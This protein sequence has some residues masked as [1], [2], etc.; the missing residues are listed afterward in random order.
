M[1]SNTFPSKLNFFGV[2]SLI[3]M[4]SLFSSLAYGAATVSP[5][6]SIFIA[7]SSGN[8][9]TINITGATGGDDIVITPPA[10]W[11]GAGVTKSSGSANVGGGVGT[12]AITVTPTAN[13]DIT[14][15]YTAKA[16]TTVGLVGF[17][18]TEDATNLA[19]MDVDVVAD[20]SGILS[21]E[22]DTVVAAKTQTA[23]QTEQTI[24]MYYTAVGS[25]TGVLSGGSLVLDIPAAFAAPTATNLKITKGDGTAADI[26]TITYAGNK[27]TVPLTTLSGGDQLK[28][29]YSNVTIPAKATYNFAISIASSSPAFGVPFKVSD[30]TVTVEGAGVGTGTVVATGGPYSAGSTG[31]T[32]TF[33]YTASGTMTGG[34]IEIVPPTGWTE[35]QGEPGRVGYT[36]VRGPDGAQYATSEVLFDVS[37]ADGFSGNG[38]GI[39]VGTLELNQALTVIYGYTGT[40][41]GAT[42]T[43][44]TG[45]SRFVVYAT[46]NASLDDGLIADGGTDDDS[47]ADPATKFGTGSQPKVSVQAGDGSGTISLTPTTTTASA[48]TT[49][50]IKYTVAGLISDGA[51][52]IKFP[53]NWPVPVVATEGD[54]RVKITDDGATRGTES[55]VGRELT[56]PITFIQAAK[57]ITVEYVA[58]A[59]STA[60]ADGSQ[61]TFKSRGTASGSLA[62]ITNKGVDPVLNYYPMAVTK[63]ANGSGSVGVDTTTVTAGSTGNIFNITYKAVGQLDGG[64]IK[65]IRPTGWT[66]DLEA[67]ISV[68]SANVV[69]DADASTESQAIYKITTLGKDQQVVFTYSGVEVPK[70]RKAN[71]VI[72]FQ[73][74]NF[75]DDTDAYA[76]VTVDL[77]P[78]VDPQVEPVSLR[79]NDATKGIEVDYAADGSGTLSI[80]DGTAT[81]VETQASLESED[82]DIVY[83]A[84]A[85]MN[86]GQVVVQIPTGWSELVKGTNVSIATVAND[87]WSVDATAGTITVTDVDLAADATI[88]ISYDGAKAP[89]AG[90]VSTFSA[91]SQ[92][93]DAEGRALAAA[94]SVAVNVTNVVKGR[95]KASILY[96]LT[97]SAGADTADV[98]TDDVF[99][100]EFLKGATNERLVF[101]FEAVGPMSGADIKFAIDSDYVTA[102]GSNP[103]TTSPTGVAYASVTSA[104]AGS[105]TAL[106]LSPIQAKYLQLTGV[107]LSAGQSIEVTLANLSFPET[108]TYNFPTYM[109]YGATDS[110]ATGS[111]QESDTLAAY[112]T[113]FDLNNTTT[114]LVRAG[115]NKENLPLE[116]NV[117]SVEGKGTLAVTP[118]TILRNGTVNNF[119]FQFTAAAAT[120]AF[121][122]NLNS[123]ITKPVVSTTEAPKSISDAGFVRI[124][125]GGGTLVVDEDARTI[126]V[127]ELSLL[128]GQSVTVGYYQATFAGAGNA[129]GV[130]AMTFNA[131]STSDTSASP[132]FTTALAPDSV[133]TVHFVSDDGVGI[134]T[135]STGDTTPANNS[136]RQVVMNGAGTQAGSEATIDFYYRLVTDRYISSGDL[137]LV[138]PS[139]WTVPV[140]GTAA[141]RTI[142]VKLNNAAF[143]E[144]DWGSKITVNGRSIIVAIDAMTSIGAANDVLQVSYKG[145]APNNIAESSVTVLQRSG[146]LTGRTDTAL[147]RKRDAD[148]AAYISGSA[149]ILK[150]TYGDPLAGTVTSSNHLA[151]VSAGSTGHTFSFTYTTPVEISP[152]TDLYLRIPVVSGDADKRWSAAAGFTD[153]ATVNVGEITTS[154]LPVD[155]ATT[156]INEAGEVTVADALVSVNT[157]TLKAGGSLTITY[158]NATAPSVADDEYVTAATDAVPR[159]T[160]QVF[161]L[162]INGADFTDK[163]AGTAT[164]ASADETSHL[165]TDNTGVFVTTLAAPETGTGALTLAVDYTTGATRADPGDNDTDYDITN[166]D[167]SVTQVTRQQVHAGD[168]GV[169]VTLNYTSAGKMDGQYIRLIVPDG[170]SAPQGNPSLPGYTSANNIGV[171]VGYPS[172]S[173]QTV[174][175]PIVSLAYGATVNLYYG[176]TDST[177]GAVVPN[178]A[179]LGDSAP[180]FQ[181]QTSSDGTAWTSV[182]TG[183][184]VDIVS[185]RRGTGTAVISPAEVNAGETVN[186]TVTYTATSTMN[187]GSVSL[188]KPGTFTMAGDTLAIKNANWTAD[189]VLKD[190]ADAVIPIKVSV[191]TS[192]TLKA[193]DDTTTPVTVPF[194]RT[195]PGTVTAYIDTLPVGGTVTFTINELIAPTD[196]SDGLEFTVSATGHDT[197]LL[198][199]Q[200]ADGVAVSPK[201]VVIG[202]KNGSGAAVLTTGPTI[203]KVGEVFTT[204]IVVTYTPAAAMA[205]G[206]QVT[207]EIP[208]GWT[209]PV[210][211]NDPDTA[212][213]DRNLLIT[214]I[215]N[216]GTD[217]AEAIGADGQTYVGTVGAN[218]IDEDDEVVF[219]Y[220]T[221]TAQATAGAAV[222]NVRSSI[223][224]SPAAADIVSGS[225]SITV[226]QAGGGSGKLAID[227][228]TKEVNTAGTYTFTYTASEVVTEGAVTGNYSGWL[229]CTSGGRHYNRGY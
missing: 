208:A 10:G 161:A 30:L 107:T 94:G 121:R 213:D 17:T 171:T 201:V 26:G 21:F 183:I 145:T 170:W 53:A 99:K 184:P 33:T 39:K 25:A 37:T 168:T 187:G 5:A 179:A 163:A 79:P 181:V 90:G 113:G 218:G 177:K 58:T 63:A 34:R 117:Q 35:P 27:V 144:E 165:P 141:E 228:A 22:K 16:G 50:T 147:N 149:V 3:V 83:T 166:A 129:N 212:D 20:G 133:P 131:N 38:V 13:G 104:P 220:K 116:V 100:R 127:Q 143:S 159:T 68:N 191:V 126:V 180:L 76:D 122:I 160:G 156:A 46:P 158:N 64:K 195:Q 24:D 60:S 130:G 49:V 164:D 88:V 224:G 196:T 119:Q 112:Y 229:D 167:N 137:E 43:S 51:F 48:L 66:T 214:G 6:S 80:T 12:A 87:K 8:S 173:G 150:T 96:P 81:A 89:P 123:D 172:Y 192:G 154:T 106:D 194:V 82:L 124:E 36:I 32:I 18:V 110:W 176:A 138:I 62:V 186:Y 151:S 108:A 78:V 109:R 93:S 146:N 128:A 69:L 19:N 148:N 216:T 28:I 209:A 85:Q 202:A 73:V 193:A 42:A 132:G 7:G 67:N 91:T 111:D 210:I 221:P 205:A 29:A 222:F 2:F 223:T 217:F 65:I 198:A 204:N 135:T 95:G 153:D 182:G 72:G 203:T 225:P 155:D 136:E 71:N 114:G 45:F 162:T 75:D 175:F 23:G 200:D 14:I 207:L 174:S 169:K 206:A 11:V 44:S 92:G 189:G 226:A 84:F 77:S 157:G 1:N 197:N 199:I 101:S 59:P 102:L 103:Q 185:A 98:T 227:P 219:T 105:Y 215:S 40:A 188:V 47:L 97:Q 52:H 70:T 115:V 120:G 152:T 190:A 139:D 31:N 140:K 142:E 55:L 57:S 4:L 86:N 134:V 118:S 9:V 74:T 211:V 125:Q 15:V 41:S 56:I 178:T 54:G 61:F